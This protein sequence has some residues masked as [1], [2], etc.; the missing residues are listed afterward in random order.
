MSQK[1]F[2]LITKC[3]TK[4]E[5]LEEN[6]LNAIQ[7]TGLIGVNRISSSLLG[8]A[9]AYCTDPPKTYH[10]LSVAEGVTNFHT[11]NELVSLSKLPSDLLLVHS[12]VNKS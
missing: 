2:K 4:A 9:V 6:I 1:P 11:G 7:L 5:N 10:A 12:H 8:I 3:I